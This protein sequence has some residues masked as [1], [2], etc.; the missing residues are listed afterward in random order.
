VLAAA[1]HHLHV[2]SFEP[3]SPE[4]YA[5]I[6]PALAFLIP[7]EAGAALTWTALPLIAFCLVPAILS[8]PLPS[9]PIPGVHGPWPALFQHTTVPVPSPSA[10][11]LH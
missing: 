9:D 4:V 11:I 8:V 3:L 10:D 2:S 7:G 6:V 1:R 5:G